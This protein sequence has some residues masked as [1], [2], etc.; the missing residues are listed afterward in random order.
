M[1]LPDMRDDF[2]ELKDIAYYESRLKIRVWRRHHNDFDSVKMWAWEH[3]N[4]VFIWHKKH[5]IINLPFILGIQRPWQKEMMLKYGHNGAVAMNVTF[6][7][8]V[9]KCPLFSLLVFDDWR[10]NINLIWVLTS[11]M[12]EEDLVTWLQLLRWHLQKDKEDFL[13]SCFIVDDANFQKNAIKRTWLEDEV[14][15]YLSSFHILKN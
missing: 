14:P 4:D 5:D 12:I 13:M 8:N 2:V 9:S 10:N 6:G 7:T 1:K 11:R 15:I 3:P